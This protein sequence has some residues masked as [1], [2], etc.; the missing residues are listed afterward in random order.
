[1]LQQKSQQQLQKQ[2]AN[3][4]DANTLRQKLNAAKSA[5]SIKGLNVNAAASAHEKMAKN[6]AKNPNL[7]GIQLL[8]RLSPNE[9]KQYL[10]VSAELPSSALSSGVP[11]NRFRRQLQALKAS[12]QA[13]NNSF[14]VTDKEQISEAL[15]DEIQPPPML[16][17]KRTGIRIFPDGRRVAMYKNDRLDLVFTIPY[18]PAVPTPMYTIPGMQAEETEE[19]MESLEQVAKYASEENP[20][21]STRHF[22]FADGTKMPVAHGA[23][24]AIHMVHGA[25]ND[26]NKKKFADM[27]Q[28]PKG[29]EK[30]ANF[31]LS[32]V[33]FTI[34]K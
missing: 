21:S 24:K 10:A 8:G 20:K 5:L 11:V 33:K 23:A 13:L 34:N 16:V 12:R 2:Q 27:L 22:K 18:T 3:K 19:I 4:N 14:D 6:A 17:L 26:E 1:M 32:K 29:F 31:A 30:A 9:R 15:K 28:N 7:Q 25:L